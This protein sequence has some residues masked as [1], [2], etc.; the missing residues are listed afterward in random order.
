MIGVEWQMHS[1][2]RSQRKDFQMVMRLYNT[3]PIQECN[4]IPVLVRTSLG[5][6]QISINFACLS[7]APN[8]VQSCCYS[9]EWIY[10]KSHQSQ[11]FFIDT[12]ANICVILFTCIVYFILWSSLLYFV[13]FVWIWIYS[14][15]DFMFI[16]WMLILFVTCVTSFTLL[17][18]SPRVS[19]FVYY[20]Y[21]IVNYV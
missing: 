15:M 8:Y 7:T 5:F 17:F 10:S 16:C 12:F 2:Y 21:L 11:T 3:L 19:L 13:Y 14:F 6:L 20:L 9:L 1:I 18:W 4:H